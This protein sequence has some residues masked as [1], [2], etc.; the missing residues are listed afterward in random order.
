LHRAVRSFLIDH[1]ASMP[2]YGGNKSREA[3]M[4]SMNNYLD[5][6]T[7]VS[8]RCVPNGEP[9]YFMIPF[10]IPNVFPP[11]AASEQQIR[12]SHALL[13]ST[14]TVWSIDRVCLDAWYINGTAQPI[15]GGSG[16]EESCVPQLPG[17][18]HC[19][20]NCKMTWRLGPGG[21]AS[22]G[23]FSLSHHIPAPHITLV[24]QGTMAEAK[25]GNTGCG[26][27]TV[28]LV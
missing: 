19:H 16:W 6:M 22:W 17:F 4:A 28:L 26:H 14:G 20:V 24:T 10:G 3:R 1:P 18:P 23:R 5:A 27:D 7:Y 8:H 15:L 13:A 12:L 21:V 25:Y 2:H 9:K 11:N